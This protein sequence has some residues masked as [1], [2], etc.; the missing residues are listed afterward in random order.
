MISI[1]VKGRNV[2]LWGQSYEVDG[3]HLVSSRFSARPV[4]LERARDS[5]PLGRR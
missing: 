3:T 2:D 1:I 5:L 4:K